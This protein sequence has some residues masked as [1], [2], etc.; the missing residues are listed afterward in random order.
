MEGSGGKFP[1]LFNNSVNENQKRGE[2]KREKE[3]KEKM[4]EKRERKKEIKRKWEK[5]HVEWWRKVGG[6][7]P[8]F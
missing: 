7:F 8:H 5:G 3:R 2:K 1:P 4:K 6:S